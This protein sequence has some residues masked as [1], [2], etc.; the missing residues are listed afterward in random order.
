MQT[1]L[2][3]LRTYGNKRLI[4]TLLMGFSSGLPIGLCG[5]TLQAWYTVAGINIVTIGFLTL[6]GQ[7]YTYKFLWA[8]L[9]DRF[10][11]PFLGRR[12]GWI[13]LMQLVL[14]MVLV[15]MAFLEPQANSL[16]LGLLALAVAF[17]SATQDIAIDAY[18]TDL[19]KPDER[20]L[21]AAMVTAGY[22][23]AML[24]SG[25]LALILAAKIGWRH[26]YLLM[27]LFMA[28]EIIVTLRSPE[29]ETHVKPPVS[30]MAAVMEPC[31]ELLAR[32]SIIAIL[33]FIVIYK[34]TDAFA[35]AL[36][37]PFLI[38]GMGFT[39]V[40]VGV[41]YK[42]VGMA[43]T[44]LGAFAGGIIM[45]RM[46]LYKALFI[47]GVLQ[48]V[49]NLTYMALAILGKSYFMLVTAV[50]VDYFCSALGTV[51]FVAFLMSLCDARY[52][53]TQF[54]LVSAL[55]AIGRVFVGPLAAVMVER[56]GWA[57]FYFWS[58][59]IAL[60]S[61]VLLWWIR[62]QIDASGEILAARASVHNV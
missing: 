54:A 42:G 31:K 35:L 19:L 22:R 62:E 40:Q 17:F 43:A 36:G 12:R 34:L 27:A 55:S 1:I 13:L 38:R 16:L 24:I 30:L 53:A 37:T 21:G 11:P 46:R 5:S 41:I 49:S 8:P 26:T 52:T 4:V 20:G 28:L 44:L 15:W 47:F 59:M 56:V 48:G 60:P 58:A 9:L 7:P 39:L 61:L 50:S 2:D 57:H 14:A 3:F 6:V 29:P 33:I 10:V 18:R 51:A 25:G 23:I 45:T 32:K